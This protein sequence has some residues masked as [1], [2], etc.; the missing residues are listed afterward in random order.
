MI[1]LTGATGAVG[2]R[3]LDQLLAAGERVRCL[4]RDPTRLGPRRVDVQL[5]LWTL[6]DARLPGGA[7]RGVD[8]VVHL[9]GPLHDQ[10]TGTLEELNVT[11]SWRLADAAARAGV[12]HFVHVSALGAGQAAGCRFLRA[13]EASERVVVGAGAISGMRVTTVAPSLTLARGHRWAWW[14]QALSLL[15][16]T[17]IPRHYAG[18]S[19]PIAADDVAAALV[20][21][22][23][24][25]PETL[26]TAGTSPHRLELAG[27]EVYALP[28]LVHEM[29]AAVGRPRRPTIALPIGMLRVA[30]AA[31]ERPGV[32]ERDELALVTCDTA[33]RRGTADAEALG[34]RPRS[35]RDALAR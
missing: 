26:A 34:V 30:T 31:L 24:N 16:M 12:R 2:V 6:T 21:L 23:E 27:P 5:A 25:G 29:Q 17:P 4:V 8:T 10:A 7:L 1:L 13:K 19:A 28:D 11:A 35:V 33:G 3:V 20:A 15:P 14:A 9:A 18:R 32:A 22:V